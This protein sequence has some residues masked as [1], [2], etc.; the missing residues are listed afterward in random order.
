M[1]RVTIGLLFL[2]CVMAS[3]AAA[4][5]PQQRPKWWQGDQARQLGLTSEQSA[6]IEKINQESMPRLQLANQDFERAQK[7][8]ND[9][10]MADRTTEVDVVRQ[11]VQVQAARNEF[12]R[13]WTLMLFRIYRQLT[14]DQRRK[15]DEIRQQERREREGRRG[16]PPQHP[17]QRKKK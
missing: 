14:P 1:F 10:I 6:N 7:E 11:L 2:L 3:T 15:V 8:L 5:L 17:P 12:N 16:D 13:Q 9:L 4:G